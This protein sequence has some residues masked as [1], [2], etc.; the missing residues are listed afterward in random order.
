MNLSLGF[1][2]RF[3]SNNR[4]RGCTVKQCVEHFLAAV[5]EQLTA[6]YQ[7]ESKRITDLKEQSRLQAGIFHYL[8][9]TWKKGKS[10][11]GT[12]LIDVYEPFSWSD[13][14]YKVEVGPYIQEFTNVHHIEELF[15]ALCTKTEAMF[16]SEQYGPRF[17]DYRFQVVLEFEDDKTVCQ[18][19]KELLNNR[20]LEST[21]QV[22]ATFIE[23]KVMAELPVRPS[24]NDEFFF[25]Q[26]LV[27]PHFFHQTAEEVEPLIHRLQE[28]HRAN[29]ERLDQWIYYYTMAFKH[30]AEERFLTHYFEQTG[31][32]MK[33]WV[34]IT[35]DPVQQLE[36]E[37]LDFFLYV[38]LKIGQKEPATRL[39][40]LELAKQ[41]GSRQ[42]ADYLE[43]GSG[44]FESIRKRDV[45]QGQANDI[46]Q[47]IDIRVMV[48]EEAAYREALC[49]INQLLEEGFPK[50][51]K[52]TLKSKAKNYL[53]IKKL[54]KSKLHQFFANCLEFPNL[55]P[56]LADYAQ[57]AME[58]FT[59]YQDVEP[60]EKSA[61]PGTYAV[62]GLG[63][64]SRDYFTLVQR[65]MLLVDT[66]HQSVQDAYAEA[67]LEAHGLSVE[68]M[69]VFVAILLGASESAKPLKGIDIRE[70]DLLVALR[71]ELE[72]KED[73]QRAFALYQIFGSSKKFAQR[74]K[75]ES[76]P[77]KDE[78]EKLLQ[79]MD[80]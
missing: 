38:A 53:P 67:F 23:T 9:V 70:L 43:K 3:F 15:S 60:S 76:A 18:Y 71:Q 46:L 39:E 19:Q 68:I 6:V 29:K 11:N 64:S 42:A 2:E 30:W 7:Q 12:I 22:L 33:E 21:K 78:L 48:E 61:M 34:L 1:S 28:K 55:F 59:W 69:P 5:W 65:Y 25:A 80:S 57:L 16:Q 75:Q 66:E 32:Y 50:G 74:L 35:E 63:L 8:K 58:E 77:I 4:K 36:Q 45:F 24:D 40:Y 72:K 52:L 10:P 49:Y 14:S 47:T 62:L 51:Y 31:D 44:R 13:S 37:K 17:F 20:K 41:L 27:N 26:Y 73:Y 79:W 54:A 56:L